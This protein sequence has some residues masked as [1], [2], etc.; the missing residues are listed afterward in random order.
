MPPHGFRA[1]GFCW[2]RLKIPEK[3]LDELAGLDLKGK[4]L[5]TSLARHLIFYGARL[6]LSNAR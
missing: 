2:L 4:I 3:H 5:S 1:L 6:P